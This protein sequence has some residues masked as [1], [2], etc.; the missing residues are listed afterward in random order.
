MKIRVVLC[1]PNKKYPV[2]L[3]R[4][5]ESHYD[6]LEAFDLHM[7]SD[8][9]LMEDY[10]QN[11][12]ADVLLVDEK[13]EID[14]SLYDNIL[15]AYLVED[16]SVDTFHGKNAIGKYQKVNMLFK[17]IFSF[18]ADNNK[19]GKEYC[20]SS[21]QAKIYLFQNAGGGNGCT[22]VA[23]AY[24][25]AMAEKSKKVL[26][27]NLELSGYVDHVFQAEKEIDFGDVLY[28]VKRNPENLAMKLMAAVTQD[29]SG[30]Y[31]IKP[32][33]NIP[34]MLEAGVQDMEL[35]ISTLERSCD[36]EIIVIDKAAGLSEID[37]AVAGYASD[38]FFVLEATEISQHKFLR[39]VSSMKLMEEG[40]KNKSVSKIKIIFNKYK[41]SQQIFSD[42]NFEILG[43][44][45][46]YDDMSMSEIIKNVSR[47]QLMEKLE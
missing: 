28:M 31:F 43:G 5:Y 22:T 14:I 29:Q 35:L 47:M 26:Y 27:L 1:T 10:L 24:A 4:Y 30:V 25:C 11:H 9:N 33:R 16:N 38:I 18:Y 32:S 34:D 37:K 8:E 2:R 45:P 42:V 36:F 39:Y 13:S 40:A 3:Q 12:D 44:I 17:E 15:C 21:E 20:F 41:N 46:Y 6:K 23:M 7:F 19:A